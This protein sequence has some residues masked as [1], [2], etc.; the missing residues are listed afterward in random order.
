MNVEGTRACCNHEPIFQT[1]H[2]IP[3]LT[4]LIKNTTE[5]TLEPLTHAVQALNYISSNET[6]A[7]AVLATGIAPRLIELCTAKKYGLRFHALRCV[8]QF[9]AGTEASTE[10]AI[11]AGFPAALRTCIS[12]EHLD[13]R[14]SACWAA[15]NIAAGSLSQAQALFD[16]DLIP[17]IL[18][19]ISNQGEEMKPRHEA[20]WILSSLVGKG[21]EDNDFL[22]RLVQA[23]CMEAFVSG[24]SSPDYRTI[25]ILIQS[26]ENVV[27]K[28]WSGQEDAVER[29]KAAGGVSRLVALRDDQD[30]RGTFVGR[31]ALGLIRS[32]F[33]EFAKRPRV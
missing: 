11:Q 16:S 27:D 3:I 28:Q 14:T 20:S 33:H 10:A 12:C 13:I 22:V 5:E 17:L 21:Q 4:K 26:L 23:N 19:V 8:G 29:F 15:S 25:S 6:A 24:L 1:R 9:T 32:H 18:H 7:E 31:R 2:I 30:T